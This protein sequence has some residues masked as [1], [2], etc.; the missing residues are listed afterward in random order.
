MSTKIRKSTIT[1]TDVAVKDRALKGV[2]FGQ[3]NETYLTVS[4]FSKFNSNNLRANFGVERQDEIIDG[5]VSDSFFTIEADNCI[6]DK[7]IELRLCR[8]EIQTIIAMLTRIVQ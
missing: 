1:A 4:F 2:T 8:D 3:V 6:D 5:K 7:S